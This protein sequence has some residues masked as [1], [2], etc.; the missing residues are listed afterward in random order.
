M[1]RPILDYSLYATLVVCLLSS[2][3]STSD[4]DKFNYDTT[5]GNDYG[6]SDWIEV[7]CLDL[8]VCKGWPDAWEMAI[9]WELQENSWYV[10]LEFV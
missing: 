7:G 5:V 1:I 10:E 6:P 2:V 9:E 3:V 8:E 4:L